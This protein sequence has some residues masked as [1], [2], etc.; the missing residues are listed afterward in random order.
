M[1]Y[2]EKKYEDLLYDYKKLERKYDEL[3]E[4]YTKIDLELDSASYRIRNELEPRI[5]Q[6]RRSYDNWAT[7]PER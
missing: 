6:E 3:K 2:Y 1:D 4:K 7:N 5:Q